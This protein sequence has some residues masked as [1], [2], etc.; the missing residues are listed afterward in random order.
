MRHMTAAEIREFLSASPHTGK[1]ATVG[2]N[3]QPHVV[4]IWFVLDG[5][6]VV[7][8]VSSSSTKARNIR[9]QR[10]VSLCVD[11]EELPYAFVTVFG[12]ATT[13]QSPPDLLDWTTRIAARY[14]GPERSVEFGQRNAG[15][16][17]LVVRIRIERVI[18]YAEV[19][20]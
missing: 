6:D 19:T 13:V 5:D 7:L 10:R 18:G 11:D 2:A 9:G 14:V 17:D 3:G 1:L 4:P 15:F 12:T 20:A 8:T 16:D